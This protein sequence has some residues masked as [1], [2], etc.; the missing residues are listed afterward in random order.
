MPLCGITSPRRMGSAGAFHPLPTRPACQVPG[1]AGLVR[2]R[3]P[4]AASA[5]R[6][7]WMLV[8][9][10]YFRPRQDKLK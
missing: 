7:P 5:Q 3:T 10:E 8:L 4:S 2:R 6:L 1:G 9:Q